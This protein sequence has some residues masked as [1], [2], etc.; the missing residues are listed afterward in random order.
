MHLRLIRE[1]GGKAEEWTREKEE[2]EGGGGGREEGEGG[3]SVQIIQFPLVAFVREEERW[4]RSMTRTQENFYSNQ[5][6]GED[7]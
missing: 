3:D 2:E 4:K 7:L 5:I 6:C 1:R